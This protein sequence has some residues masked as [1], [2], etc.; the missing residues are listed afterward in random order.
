MVLRLTRRKSLS[1][2]TREP[3]AFDGIE[4]GTK[5][6]AS[7]CANKGREALGLF[8]LT[9]EEELRWRMPGDDVLL[10]PAFFTYAG[11]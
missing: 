9:N 1:Q 3:M 4:S 10:P 7:P 8:V 6:L 5:A 2:G 11:K